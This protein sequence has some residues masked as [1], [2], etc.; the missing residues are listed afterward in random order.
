MALLHV[1]WKRV[2]VQAVQ[3]ILLL[4]QPRRLF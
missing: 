1:F 4:V 2:E 3:A